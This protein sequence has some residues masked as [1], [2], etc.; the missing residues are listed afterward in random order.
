MGADRNLNNAPKTSV[1]VTK[2]KTVYLCAKDQ[3]GH[4]IDAPASAY[5]K[6][7]GSAKDRTIAGVNVKG[8]SIEIIGAKKGTTNVNFSLAGGLNGA[9]LTVTAN[10]KEA[11]ASYTIDAG[12]IQ[13]DSNWSKVEGCSMN[14]GVMTFSDRWCQ[15]QIS[16]PFDVDLSKYKVTIQGTLNSGYDSNLPNIKGTKVVLFA[17]DDTFGYGIGCQTGEADTD[18][19]F[20]LKTVSKDSIIKMV[21][22]FVSDYVAGTSNTVTVTSMK[23]DSLA[24]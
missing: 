18:T 13:K 11:I 21:G 19:P 23:I 14:N 9:A 2:T 1:D 3:Y 16:L 4:N 5:A 12:Y 7:T 10:V 15:A 24:E 8:A 20:T 6:V 17:G 22:L